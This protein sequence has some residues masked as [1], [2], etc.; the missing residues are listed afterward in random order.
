MSDST[1]SLGL[2]IADFKL[3][4]YSDTEI[5]VEE[6]YSAFISENEEADF[7]I[8]CKS[9]LPSD[10]FELQQAVFEAENEEQKFYS[11]YRTGMGL[12]FVI[13]NQQEKNTIQ[14]IALLDENFTHWTLYSNPTEDGFFPLLYP[15]GPIIMHYMTLNTDAVMMHASG[16]FDGKNG[17]IF[18][19]FSGAGKSTMSKI[20]SD[21]HSLIIND[22][23]LI[24]R[25]QDNEFY[26]HNTP[27]YYYDNRKKTALHSIFIISHS[28]TNKIKKLEGAMAI[29]KTMAYCIQNNFDKQFIHNRLNFLSKLITKVNI[30]DLGFVNDANVVDFIIS[31]EKE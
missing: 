2:N 16:T 13:Y 24:V 30:Y 25:C 15:M 14:Q 27:M 3:N 22:D 17:R 23:R 4:L 1:Y 6:G 21:A 9:H 8:D 29:S 7:Y 12:S 20:W 11:I 26:I 5:K 19:G 10:K 28:P 18:T 31:N